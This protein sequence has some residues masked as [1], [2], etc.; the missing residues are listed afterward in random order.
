MILTKNCSPPH[1]SQTQKIFSTK[2][3]QSHTTTHLILLKHPFRR[4]HSITMP[5]THNRDKPWDTPDI[6]KWALE[7]LNPN[8]MLQVYILLKNHHL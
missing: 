6:D 4:T 3:I 5:S 7:E 8:I 2:F 1:P